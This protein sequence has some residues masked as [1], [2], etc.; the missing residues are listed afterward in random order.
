MDIQQVVNIDQDILSGTTVFA[1]TRVPVE[2]FFD[3]LNAGFSFE[4]FLNEF[5]SVKKEQAMFLIDKQ[6]QLN[7]L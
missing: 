7:F 4:E 6:Q 2:S 3:H 5:P 1:G